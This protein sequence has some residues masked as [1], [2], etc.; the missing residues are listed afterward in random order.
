MTIKNNFEVLLYYHYTPISAPHRM[1]HEHLLLCLANELKGRVILS[2]EGIN[3]TVSGKKENIERYKRCLK[4]SYRL[5]SI[6]FK[7]EGH[8]G[9]AFEKIQV[10]VKKELVH[11]GRPNFFSHNRRGQYLS[12][13]MLHS[14]LEREKNGFTLLDVRSKHE[15]ALGKFRNALTLDIDHFRDFFQRAEGL[16]KHK[17]EP[18]IT[19]CTGGV[20]CEKA[21]AFLLQQ[22]FKQVYQLHGGILKYGAETDGKHFEGSCYVFDN[23]ISTAINQV[24]AK[25]I[26]R[27]TACGAE[28]ERMINCANPRCNAHFPMC[29][30]CANETEGCCSRA[31]QKAPQKRPY[32]GTGYY[33]RKMDGYNPLCSAGPNKA[34][35]I[36]ENDE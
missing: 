14:L 1:R 32:N 17:E 10:R 15:H 25:T 3:G 5:G 33:T 19:Y 23:R 8:H 6:D 18:I 29:S 24:D 12:P 4:E 20:R 27:C 26:S 11:S 21:S 7:S 28:C 13:K 9:H 2:E 22:G 35:R 36:T 16:K 31:C 34:L 30:S